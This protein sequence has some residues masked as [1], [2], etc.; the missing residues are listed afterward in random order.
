MICVCKVCNNEPSTHVCHLQDARRD[1]PDE[2]SVCECTQY[3]SESGRLFINPLPPPPSLSLSAEIEAI[4]EEKG[5][6]S[7]TSICSLYKPHL[8]HRAEPQ[9]APRDHPPYDQH[10][11]E[12]SGPESGGGHQS[13]A[14]A[15]GGWS[16]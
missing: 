11:E 7:H 5:W 6:W 12:G 10:Y 13:R 2:V 3:L 14:T 16:L 15:Q 4:V 1:E 8:L 9:T